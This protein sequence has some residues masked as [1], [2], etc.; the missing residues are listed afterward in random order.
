MAVSLQ[1][2]FEL[3]AP[4][5]TLFV[6]VQESVV[7]TRWK[8][9]NSC[10]KK[11]NLSLKIFHPSPFS[12]RLLKSWRSPS[13][14]LSHFYGL[15][16]C[17][18]KCKCSTELAHNIIKANIRAV[19]FFEVDNNVAIFEAIFIFTLVHVVINLTSNQR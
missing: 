7:P 9:S 15:L 2:S 12:Q 3:A 11:K 1:D 19:V 8:A 10:S 13:K 4:I 17:S 14:S 16:S 18:F 5:V 6:S